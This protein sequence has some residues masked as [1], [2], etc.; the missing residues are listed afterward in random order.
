MGDKKLLYH[1]ATSSRACR[2]HFAQLCTTTISLLKNSYRTKRVSPRARFSH[3]AKLKLHSRRKIQTRAASYRT[4][5]GTRPRQE[6][7]G[8]RE[9]IKRRAAPSRKRRNISERFLKISLK[10]PCFPPSN[11]LTLLAWDEYLVLVH[12]LQKVSGNV[13]F[14]LALTYVGLSNLR[15]SNLY[16][17]GKFL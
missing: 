17:S 15:E 12:S 10:Y 5:T 8:H 3:I 16:I 1:L 4:S 14:G 7:P 9:G 2:H 13:D 11:V 6:V